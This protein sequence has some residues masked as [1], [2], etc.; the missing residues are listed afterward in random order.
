VKQIRSNSP[1]LKS[2]DKKWL[3]DIVISIILASV[4]AYFTFTA[5]VWDVLYDPFSGDRSAEPLWVWLLLLPQDFIS[6]FDI[7]SYFLVYL[8]EKV[9]PVLTL[10]FYSIIFILISRKVRK[11]SSRK[12]FIYGIQILFIFYIALKALAA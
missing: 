12:L 11:T 2:L 8:G 6:H 4:L 7:I 3:F 5:Y 10:V 1:D 9:A